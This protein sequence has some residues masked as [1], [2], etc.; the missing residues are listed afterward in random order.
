MIGC[1]RMPT[2]QSGTA[3]WGSPIIYSPPTIH[4]PWICYASTTQLICQASRQI[5]Y[6]RGQR[7][8]SF[9]IGH[10]L[11]W[12]TPQGTNSKAL[13]Y[14]GCLTDSPCDGDHIMMSNNATV[15]PCD[16]NTLFKKGSEDEIPMNAVGI[17]EVGFYNNQFSNI[18]D[19]FTGLFAPHILKASN[20]VTIA[21]T[22]D[23]CVI[24]K[25]P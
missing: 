17:I 13:M 18:I 1:K 25:T 6:R 14:Y 19:R 10:Q 12:N 24:T 21:C 11:C 2:P 8:T 16:Q 15:I 22:I 20:G 4:N 9:D 5:R 7:E 23:E 3:G